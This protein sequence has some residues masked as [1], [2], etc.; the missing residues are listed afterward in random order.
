MTVDTL[1]PARAASPV[2][3]PAAALRARFGPAI[4][5]EQ[6]TAGAFPVLWV[7]PEKSPEINRFLKD[8]I[9]RPYALLT[10]L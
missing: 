5:A 7:A 1:T 8:E 10:D 4:L 6:A 9:D 2:D 3:D